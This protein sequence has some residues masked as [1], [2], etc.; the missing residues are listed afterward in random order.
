MLSSL[1]LDHAVYDDS[2][3]IIWMKKVYF[4]WILKGHLY[5]KWVYT[6]NS[7]LYKIDS[8]TYNNNAC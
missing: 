4:L 6:Y 7:Y 2:W 5:I 3:L 1:L 8:I